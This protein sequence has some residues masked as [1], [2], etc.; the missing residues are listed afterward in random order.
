MFDNVDFASAAFLGSSS[1]RESAASRCDRVSLHLRIIRLASNPIPQCFI[2]SNGGEMKYDHSSC[3]AMFDGDS[4]DLCCSS[5]LGRC[6][7][8]E[9]SRTWGLML[10]RPQ[11]GNALGI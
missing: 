3:V 10:M 9:I 7:V 5:A 1:F 8:C 11:S 4:C 2:G 6:A